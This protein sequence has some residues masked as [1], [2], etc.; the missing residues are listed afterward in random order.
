MVSDSDRWDLIHKKNQTDPESHSK[1]AEEVEK[2]FPRGS[3]VV[4]IGS[5]TG[6]DAMYF[7]KM[8]HMVIAL[9]ISQ[10][11]LETLIKKAEYL[12]FSSKIV[13]KQTDYGL[14]KLPIKDSAVDAVYSRIA[15]NYFDKEHTS[16]LFSDIYRILKPGGRA[17]LTLKAPNDPEEMEYLEKSTVVF[18]PHVFIENGMLRSRFSLEELS[19]IAAQAQI[20][21]PKLK[22]IK[23]DLSQKGDGHGVVLHLNEITFEKV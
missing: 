11:A 2:L 4:D 19:E 5:G 1:Y 18:E 17:F 8:G 23:E 22:Y 13:V 20:P 15:L 14:H 3:L 21:N 16:R 12:G 10:F 9:D 7:L 6:L